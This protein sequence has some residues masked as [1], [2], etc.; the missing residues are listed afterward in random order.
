[1]Q[2]DIGKFPSLNYFKQLLLI[3]V[4]DLQYKAKMPFLQICNAAAVPLHS[5][6]PSYPLNVFNWESRQVMT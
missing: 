3:C 4:C 1:M 2:W 6:A 5:P